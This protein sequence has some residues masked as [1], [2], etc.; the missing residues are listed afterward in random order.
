MPHPVRATFPYVL[1]TETLTDLIKASAGNPGK[2][3]ELFNVPRR[4]L[5]AA[6]PNQLNRLLARH[7]PVAYLQRQIV[8]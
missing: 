6:L 7:A 4:S 1:I 2:G 8:E 3:T 5:I